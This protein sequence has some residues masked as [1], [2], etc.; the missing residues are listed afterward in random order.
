MRPDFAALG[1]V[2]GCRLCP[3][4]VCVRFVF[5]GFGLRIVDKQKRRR[6]RPLVSVPCPFCKF[7]S[8]F[9]NFSLQPFQPVLTIRLQRYN[10]VSDGL[11]SRLRVTVPA[12]VGVGSIVR[13]VVM[14][15]FVLPYCTA[16]LWRDSILIFFY[17]TIQTQ[18][19][20]FL[21]DSVPVWEKFF[22][23][24]V[25]IGGPWSLILACFR[26]CAPGWVGLCCSV[27]ALPAAFPR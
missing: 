14:S 15:F 5:F 4:C 6:T 10:N 9:A 25:L 24:G 11:A 7:R 2:F 17:F 26:H 21:A 20:L 8:I 27:A 1:A 12:S 13:A 19:P 16:Q 23:F 22:C 3:V 18:N